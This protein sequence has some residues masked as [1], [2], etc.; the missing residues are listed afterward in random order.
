MGQAG[1]LIHVEEAPRFWVNKFDG[2]IGV[3]KKGTE[4]SECFLRPFA[5]S[6]IPR[7]GNSKSL[8]ILPEWANSNLGIFAYPPPAYISKILLE[9]KLSKPYS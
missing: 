1:L 4:Q 6:N 2:V 5:L 9:Y 3:I 8:L 7:Q